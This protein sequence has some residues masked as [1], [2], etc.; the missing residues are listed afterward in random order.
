MKFV[1]DIDGMMCQASCGSTVE[2]ALKGVP[3][4]VGA[5]VS[6]PLHAATVICQ[7]DVT[8]DQLVDAVETVGFGAVPLSTRPPDVRL[9]VTGMMCQKNCGSTVGNALSAVPGV[10]LAVVN[11]SASEARIWGTASFIDLMD[12]VDLVGFEAEL[13]ESAKSKGNEPDKPALILFIEDG[14]GGDK[15]SGDKK[16]L[17]EKVDNVDGVFSVSYDVSTRCLQV[18]GFPELEDVVSVL[19]SIGY[20]GIEFEKYQSNMRS[21][22]SSEDN[23]SRVPENPLVLIASAKIQGI[24]GPA[25]VKSLETALIGRSGIQ[26]VKCALLTG[27]TL[28][29]FDPR[30]TGDSANGKITTPIIED[31]V[32]SL[33]YNIEI[34]GVRGTGPEGHSDTK[35]GDSD[36]IILSVSGMSCAN[37]ASKVER[38]LSQHSG[39]A[40]AT[41]SVM[42]NKAVVYVDELHAMS[43]D[44]IGVRD[45]INIVEGLGY[46]CKLVSVGNDSSNEAEDGNSGM[47]DVKEWRKLLEI[48]LLFGLPLLMIHFSMSVSEKVA[49][50]FTGPGACDGGV[51]VG[52][53]IML[54]LNTP[55]M[56][57]VG[58]RFFKAAA[59]S[60]KHGSFGMDFLVATGTSVTYAYSLLQLFE[61]CRTGESTEHVFLEVSRKVYRSLCSPAYGFSNSKSFEDATNYGMLIV[62]VCTN[63]GLHFCIFYQAVL[64]SLSNGE[65]VDIESIGTGVEVTEE[66]DVRLV[67]KGD[68]L[69]VMSGSRLPADGEIISGSSYVDESMLTGESVP[70]LKTKGDHVFGSTVNQGGSSAVSS[71]SS[72]T[73]RCSNT[74]YIKAS[75]IGSD[76]ALAQ[77]VRLV[78]DAQMNRAPIQ[79]YADKLASIF[80]PVVLTISALTFVVWYSLSVS[81][82]VP[83]IWFEEEYGD[84]FLFS[85][86]FAISVVVI[87]CPCALGLATPT[88]IM[89]G[90]SVGALNGV[91]IKGGTAFE[92]AH[93]VNAIVFDKTGTLTAGKPL[94]TDEIVL[95]QKDLSVIPA[96][97][98]SHSNDR[99]AAIGEADRLLYV[100]ACAEQQNTHPIA[101]AIVEEA[102]QRS[103]ALPWLPDSAFISEIGS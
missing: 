42:T 65:P 82:K 4:V 13:I 92:I 38:T 51:T 47:E 64:V 86:L 52:Q 31:I 98:F 8:E 93:S 96:H 87:S 5:I 60:A 77:I 97:Q 103:F 88:A 29:S 79:A 25:A 24:T 43:D 67:Q 35:N 17:E 59:I 23:H 78:E 63:F 62:I 22:K 39:V 30:V 53:I 28:I 102:K 19:R 27:H 91:L 6:F 89:V 99:E 54:V 94:V 72:T 10:L 26:N 33:G 68:V 80:T 21:K 18:W 74:L 20:S 41:V 81:G 90:T 69:K 40:S 7:G 57:L 70:V 14:K 84:P 66:I 83:R 3:G 45:L 75:S 85:L 95:I 37:C 73:M 32:L 36:K 44:A 100:A 12:A 34:T 2:A 48:A 61:A 1:L 101:S 58:R 16:R 46:G 11:F 71:I 50:A 9:R 55:I 56:L 76:S 15:A 49:M